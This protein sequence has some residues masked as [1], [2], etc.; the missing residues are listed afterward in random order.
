M[1][2]NNF[3]NLLLLREKFKLRKLFKNAK[4]YTF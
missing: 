3:L 2:T 1:F 4:N